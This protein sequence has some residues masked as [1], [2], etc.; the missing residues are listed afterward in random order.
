MDGTF[1]ERLAYILSNEIMDKSD[2]YID[3]HGGEFNE[4]L[5]NFLVF[6]YGCPDKELCRQ[7]RLMAH[8]VGNT[9]M[10][11]FDYSSV[12]DDMPSEY[13]SKVISYTSLDKS[14]LFLLFRYFS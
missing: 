6:Y 4:R 5:L 3:M 11:P 12:P 1:S 2:Y 14:K 7:S 8:A 10:I 9:H 13:F